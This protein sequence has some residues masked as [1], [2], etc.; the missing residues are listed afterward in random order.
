MDGSKTEPGIGAGLFGLGIK[1][2]TISSKL[3]WECYERLNNPDK[4]NRGELYWAPG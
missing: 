2:N 1:S 3:D 4:E